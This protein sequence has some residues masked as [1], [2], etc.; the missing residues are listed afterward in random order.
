VKR[1]LIAGLKGYKKIISPCLMKSCRY[2]PTCSEYAVEAL[3]KFGL[4]RGAMLSTW[5]ILRC[6]PFSRGGYD[7]VIGPAERR[8][9][10]TETQRG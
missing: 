7:P 4:V 8:K 5:R 6:N 9:L 1:V 10:T 2:V 3:E